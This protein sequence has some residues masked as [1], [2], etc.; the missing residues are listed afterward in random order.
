[1]VRGVAARRGPGQR[2]SAF[3]RAQPRSRSRRV[4]PVSGARGVKRPGLSAASGFASRGRNT[5]R[6]CPTRPL[7]TRSWN[8]EAGVGIVAGALVEEAGRVASQVRLGD[9]TAA[10]SVRRTGTAEVAVTWIEDGACMCGSSLCFRVMRRAGAW[11]AAMMMVASC[12]PQSAGTVL[13]V[14]ERA[15]ASVHRDL[16]AGV[17]LSARHGHAHSTAMSSTAAAVTADGA[18]MVRPPMVVAVETAASDLL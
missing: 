11:M 12:G 3:G 7:L 8:R 16:V 4:R 15:R 9:T 18:Y 10:N 13:P 14:R 5:G 17:D 1:M 2:A 6:T